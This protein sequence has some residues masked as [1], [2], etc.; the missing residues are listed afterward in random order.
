MSPRKTPDKPAYW[1]PSAIPGA[2]GGAMAA[3]IR[4]QARMVEA[5]LKQNIEALDFLRARFEKD[6]DL[7]DRL[8]TAEDPSALMGLWTEFWQRMMSDYSSETGKLATSMAAIAEEA[9]KSATDEGKAMS[10]ALKPG[11]AN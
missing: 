2:S 9:L 5:L 3:M 4:P 6:R 8:A 1:T 11:D 7:M 10:A